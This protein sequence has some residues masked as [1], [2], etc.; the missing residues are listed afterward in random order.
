MKRECDFCSD[1]TQEIVHWYPAEDF[2]I[3]ANQPPLMSTGGWAACAKCASLIN[4]GEW[5][6]LANHSAETFQHRHGH[7]DSYLFK[8]IIRCHAN[9]RLHR[10]DQ[11]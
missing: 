9:F 4:L 10:K 11:G 8:E 5:N 7:I 6:A 3:D 1:N 2:M